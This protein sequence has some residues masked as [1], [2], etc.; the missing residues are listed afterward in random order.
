M[1]TET[2]EFIGKNIEEVLKFEKIHDKERNEK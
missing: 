2:L 1:Q